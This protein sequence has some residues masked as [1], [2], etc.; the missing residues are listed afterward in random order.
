MQNK[1]IITDSGPVIHLSEVG[2]N[3]AWQVFPNVLVPDIVQKEISIEQL[4]G[5]ETLEDKRFE[6]DV[7]NKEIIALSK[8]LFKKHDMGKNDSLVLAHAIY[9]KSDLLLTDDLQMREFAKQEEITPVGSIGILYFAFRK[10][11]CDK[12]QLFINLDLL[13]SKSSLYITRDIIERVKR[14]AEQ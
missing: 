8:K 9:H 13:F 12:K 6:V 11:L 5:T 2:A 10:R 4:P 1:V 14:E 7:K 3:F